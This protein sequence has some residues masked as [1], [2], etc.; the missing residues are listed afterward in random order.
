MVRGMADITAPQPPAY[1]PPAYAPPAATGL[2]GPTGPTAATARPKTPL[3]DLVFGWRAALAVLLAGIVVGG[4]VG[5]AITLI[6][7]HGDRASTPS[8]FGTGFGGFAPYGQPGQFGQSQQG[9]TGS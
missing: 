6:V 9:G 7:D 1:G 5:S 2:T 4:L 8:R 3:R